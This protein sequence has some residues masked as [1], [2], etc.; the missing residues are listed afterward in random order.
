[1]LFRLVLMKGKDERIGS[2]R[3]SDP[4][5]VISKAL[6]YLDQNRLSGATSVRIE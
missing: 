2:L 6:A 1:M 3:W 4:E 5:T